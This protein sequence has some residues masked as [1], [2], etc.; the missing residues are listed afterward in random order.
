MDILQ[1]YA[2]PP[3]ATSSGAACVPVPNSQ[4]L[5]AFASLD[6][7]MTKDFRFPLIPWLSNHQVRL[8]GTIFNVTDHYNPRD[9]IN[10]VTTSRYGEFL[11]IQHRFYDVGFDIIY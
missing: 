4:R 10:N 3:S 2:C 8:S 5:P 11:G 6:L 1:N 9:V 7:K